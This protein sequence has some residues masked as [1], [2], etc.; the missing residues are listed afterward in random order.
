MGS[1]EREVWHLR[2]CLWCQTPS[3]WSSRCRFH[4]CFMCS[5]YA[6]RSQK[7][8]MTLLTWLSFFAH[9]GSA[10]VK[11]VRKMLMKWSPGGKYANGI[12]VKKYKAGYSSH[13]TIW[14]LALGFS[15]NIF[16][17]AII[18]SYKS[19]KISKRLLYLSF[20]EMKMSFKSIITIGELCIKIKAYIQL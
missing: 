8:Q 1:D 19:N 15:L 3:A 18:L 13:Y 2:W 16:W 10:C 20:M 17:I 9:L 12:I 5:F 14:A 11:A 4:Q 6:R 7:R